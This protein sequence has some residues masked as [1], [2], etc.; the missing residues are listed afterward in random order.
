MLTRPDGRTARPVAGQ[1]S[2]PVPNSCGWHCAPWSWRE[3]CCMS[4]H[5]NGLPDRAACF[6]LSPAQSSLT[7]SAAAM[8][9]S[10]GR[11]TLMSCS[12]IVARVGSKPAARSGRPF[13]CKR[14]QQHSHHDHR[15]QCH[16]QAFGTVRLPWSATG[17]S[18]APIDRHHR[19][20]TVRPREPPEV[21]R[22][23]FANLPH[24][25]AEHRTTH[26]VKS[27]ITRLP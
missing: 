18:S 15:V 20:K 4:V 26:R 27:D 12:G 9:S 14:M 25:G 17:A 8:R 19:V 24:I 21:L 3:C 1:G 22:V 5:G 23:F 16:P 11:G 13:P 10:H 7:A 6:E 2:L